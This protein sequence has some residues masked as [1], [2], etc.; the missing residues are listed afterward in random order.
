[1]TIL[2]HNGQ[3]K[4]PR[5]L[6][7]REKD[8]LYYLLPEER[9]AYAEYRRNIGSMLV[10]GEGRFGDGNLVLGYE[11]DE[12]D[13]SYSSL[14][15]F[16]CGQ[17][18]FEGGSLQVSIHEFFD[19]KI[20]VSINNVAGEGIPDIISEKNRWTY[21]YWK[22]GEMSPFE[23]DRLREVNLSKNKNEFVLALSTANHSIWLYE[24]VSGVNHIIPVTNFVNELLRGNK[25]IDRTK[26]INVAYVFSVLDKF[27]DEDFVRAFVQYNKHWRKVELPDS[28]V[29]H[30][31]EKKGLFK[32]LFG[33]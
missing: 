11:G 22:P 2:N 17:I 12:P 24:A 3:R 26:G 14:P 1:M 13:L 33:G 10:I 5:K 6:T 8:W 4:Y 23:G 21:S 29:A 9:H 20:E 16:A 31:K 30:V 27:P 32:K 19:N 7:K 25:S 15:V 28:D 18:E